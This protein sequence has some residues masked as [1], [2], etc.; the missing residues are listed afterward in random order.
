MSSDTTITVPGKWN[1]AGEE[2]AVQL[3]PGEPRVLLRVLEVRMQVERVLTGAIGPVPSGE[4][5]TTL[6]C[7]FRGFERGEA[8]DER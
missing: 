1:I 7:Q 8:D 5:T 2:I 4:W 6:R 3:K